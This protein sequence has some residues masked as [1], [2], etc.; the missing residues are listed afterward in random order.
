MGTVRS[1]LRKKGS[2]FISVPTTATVLWALERM[3]EHNIGALLVMDDEKFVG[4]FTER[5]YARKVIVKG[6]SS[7]DTLIKEI[8]TEHPV[9]VT[10]DH[11]IE[12]CMDLMT[13]HSFRHLPVVHG[14]QLVGLVSVLDVVKHVI[15]EQKSTINNLEK[16]ITG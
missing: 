10:P 9:T 1:I 8:M 13:N 7:R 16:Y 12:S 2:A 3:V 14:D 5:D 6:K 4:I 11:T 15:D